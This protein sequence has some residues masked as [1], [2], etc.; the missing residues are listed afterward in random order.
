MKNPISIVEVQALHQAGRLEEARQGYLDILHGHPDDV[1]AWHYLGVLYAEQQKWPEAQAC[2]EKALALQPQDPALTLHLANIFKSSGKP[3]EALR[4]LQSVIKKHPNFAAAYN[5]LG[6]IYYAMGQWQEAV[7]AYRSALEKQ[8]N[9]VDAYY[10]LG[11]A[12]NK[13]GAYQEALISFES[14]FALAPQHPGAHFQAGC[15]LMQKQDYAR[16]MAHFNT[17]EAVHPFHFE[18]QTNLATCYLKLGKWEAAK[19]HYLKALELMPSDIQ[20]LYNLGLMHMHQ[21][22]LAEAEKYYL[23]V[24]ELKPDH[25]DTHNNL[26]VIYLGLRDIELALLHFREVLRLQPDNE[27]VRHTI[28]IISGDKSIRT[29]PP[30][31]IRALFNSYADH[32]DEHLR[33]ALHYQVPKQLVDMLTA[34]DPKRTRYDVVLDAGCGTGLCGEWL[35]PMAGRLIGVDLSEN[36]LAVAEAKHLYDELILD[37]VVLHLQASRTAYDL[38]AAGDTVVYFGEIEALFSAVSG[39]LKPDGYFI[40]NA[41]EGEKAYELQPSGRFSHNKTYIENV[42]ARHGMQVLHDEEAVLRKQARQPVR[43]RLYLLGKVGGS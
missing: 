37:E 25:I 13:A 30:A 5:N 21:G 18:T 34:Y 7:A 4:M 22:L 35:R 23:R 41:E 17:I 14:L 33:Q 16:A 10:N 42:A 27:A 31:Y 2:L 36:M 26:G 9:Y 43:G 8:A 12:L 11:L 29:S 32:F 28:N 24:V 39:A 40:F 1:T 38:I 3:L 19:T 15:L 6:T 20:V